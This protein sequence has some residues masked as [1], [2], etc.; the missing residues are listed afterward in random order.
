MKIKIIKEN[1]NDYLLQKG[2]KF[3]SLSEGWTTKEN[4][5]LL[6]KELAKHFKIMES[7]G[8]E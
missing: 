1:E 4:A 7:Y 6:T 3:F 8:D 2:N 5:T